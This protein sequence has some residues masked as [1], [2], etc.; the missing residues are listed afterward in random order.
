MKVI[1][2]KIIKRVGSKEIEGVMRLINGKYSYNYPGNRDFEKDLYDSDKLKISK[3]LGLT[4][5]Y[6]NAV[7]KG[8]KFNEQVLLEAEILAK[9]NIDYLKN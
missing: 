6:V 8:K 4:Q 1:E 7:L 3:K 5:V 9:F 2:K